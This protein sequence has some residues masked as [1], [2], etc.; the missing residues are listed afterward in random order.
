MVS[1][2]LLLVSMFCSLSIHGRALAGSD[3]LEVSGAWL[4]PTI[5]GS[6]MTALY[7]SV[8]NNGE[9]ADALVGVSTPAAT[10][11]Q[12]HES[13]V[14]DGVVSMLPVEALPLP[15]HTVVVL[16]P[17]ATHVMLLGLTRLLKT[18][19]QIPVTLHFK[20]AGDIT[21]PAAVSMTPPDAQP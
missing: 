11:S 21:V 8:K 20:A 5:G 10:N 17:K 15:S 7:M 9:V 12:L 3:G 1:R 6:P 16:E 18:G 2:W 4:R 14:T 13:R 19:D